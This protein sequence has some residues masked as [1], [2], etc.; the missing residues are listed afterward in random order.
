MPPKPTTPMP[1]D[2]EAVATPS[3]PY[4][5]ADVDEELFVP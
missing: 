3:T 4:S 2:A 5:M 1:V